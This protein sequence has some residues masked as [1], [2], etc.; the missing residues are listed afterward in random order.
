MIG[1]EQHIVHLPLE[2]LL[3]EQQL[4][5]VLSNGSFSMAKPLPEI[6]HC[7]NLERHAKWG[8][9]A[10]NLLSDSLSDISIKILSL[11][12]SGVSSLELRINI[13]NM[14]YN[15]KCKWKA[16]RLRDSISTI[17]DVFSDPQ[18]IFIKKC[19]RSLLS[20]CNA[21][22]YSGADYIDRHYIKKIEDLEN[23]FQR[24]KGGVIASQYLLEAI[25][26]KSALAEDLMT[27]GYQHEEMEELN[28]DRN[29]NKTDYFYY[30]DLLDR[31]EAGFNS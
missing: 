3:L 18:S 14:I 4:Q 22:N 13:W 26:F 11:F 9:Y 12:E 8:V 31:K 25:G 16:R 24:G 30:P 7:C 20:T 27:T 29:H 2:L 28:N 6:G 23:G 17:S 1:K 10:A 5:D 21:M 19:V 15:R